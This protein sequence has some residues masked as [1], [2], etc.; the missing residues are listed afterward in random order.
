[1]VGRRDYATMHGAY[2]GVYMFLVGTGRYQL[3]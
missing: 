1:M 3:I 2:D